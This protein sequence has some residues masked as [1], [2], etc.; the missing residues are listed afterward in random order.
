MSS[1]LGKLLQKKKKVINF[2]YFIFNSETNT[3]VQ[4]KN[5]GVDMKLLF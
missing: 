1:V 4:L 3:R 2:S 5:T